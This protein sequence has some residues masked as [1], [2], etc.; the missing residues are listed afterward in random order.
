MVAW[1]FIAAGVGLGVGALVVV[2]SRKAAASS[3]DSSACDAICDAAASQGVPADLCK[4]GVTY[5]LCKASGGLLGDLIGA[6]SGRDWAADDAENKKLNG[7]VELVLGP[8]ADRTIIPTTRAPG[9]HG[10]VLRFKS[11]AVPFRGWPGWEKC[12]PGTHD[13]AS[14]GPLLT[15]DP[16]TNRWVPMVATAAFQGGQGDPTSAGPFTPD[17][18]FT[19]P[20]VTSGMVAQQQAFIDS[21][22]KT[23]TEPAFPLPIP[24]GSRGYYAQGIAFVCPSGTSPQWGLR[25]HRASGGPPPCVGADG[26]GGWGVDA[27]LAAKL[28]GDTL[29]VTVGTSLPDS[30]T[31]GG[32]TVTHTPGGR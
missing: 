13:M 26:S 6:F 31:H 12:A 2:R 3:G 19:M 15:L 9:L 27:A 32:T 10:T 28:L 17:R 25:D 16:V 18:Q 1:G 22:Q 21:A 30:R 24:S 5:Q 7:E 29:H 11:G 14:S 23:V 8:L 4:Q 20:A